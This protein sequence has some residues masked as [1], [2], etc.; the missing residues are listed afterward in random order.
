M[1]SLLSISLLAGC[2]VVAH[3]GPAR[4]DVSVGVSITDGS[5]SGF[6]LA[7]GEF[8][9]A[10]HKEVV[11]LQE[12]NVSDDELPV[13]YFLARRAQVSPLAI[14]KL[15]LGGSSWMEISLHLGLSAD[16]YY[17]PVEGSPGPPYGKA[18]GHFKKHK[19]SKWNTIRLSDVDIV[20]LVNLQFVSQHYGYSPTEVIKQRGAGKSFRHISHG[21]EKSRTLSKVSAKPTNKGLKHK[22]K[23]PSKGKG[24]G[25]SNR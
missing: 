16:M 10:P 8:Y 18:L 22:A 12:K 20:N 19:K 11:V 13:V 24:K 2:I 23:S 21:I 25:K 7:I 5:L 9:E 15:R 14:L 3:P 6:H 17:V 4:S 1:R